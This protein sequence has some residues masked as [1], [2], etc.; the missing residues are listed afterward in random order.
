M[1]STNFTPGTTIASSWLNDADD[2][3]YTLSQGG[4]PG[5]GDN[6][7]QLQTNRQLGKASSTSSSGGTL[8][9]SYYF[10]LNNSGTIT[11]ADSLAAGKLVTSTT[12]ISTEANL[13]VAYGSA[14]GTKK[15]GL[16]FHTG[17]VYDILQA[18]VT[19]TPTNYNNEI[20]GVVLGYLNS[21]ARIVVQD[22][23]IGTSTSAAPATHVISYVGNQH[24]FI[25]GMA[26]SAPIT[27]TTSTY[28][29]GA[30][31]YSLI[32]NV[33]ASCTVTLPEADEENQGRILLVKNTAA[34]TVISASSNVI[35][36]TGGAAGTAILSATAGKWAQLQ[37]DGTNWHILMAN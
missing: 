8:T 6:A 9:G 32:F 26:I 10:D 21:G 34:F 23:Y 3:I 19:T 12:T 20:N 5:G 7:I 33:S 22:Q 31:I 4:S 30:N 18:S 28:T 16:A 14:F 11:S 35:P 36:I 24:K 29:V 25:G 1:A 27:V 13:N 2:V 37:S 15:V 17:T